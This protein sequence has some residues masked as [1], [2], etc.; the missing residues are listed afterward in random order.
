MRANREEEERRRKKRGKG[1]RREEEV[2]EERLK[3]L[4]GERLFTGQ[5][6]SDGVGRGA[7]PSVDVLRDGARDRKVGC[8]VCPAGHLHCS[9]QSLEWWVEG[10]IGKKVNTEISK[11]SRCSGRAAHRSIG[12]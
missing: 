11:R 6:A 1:R 3:Y 9:I 5:A 4:C 12:R 2:E 8:L 10:E 7:P